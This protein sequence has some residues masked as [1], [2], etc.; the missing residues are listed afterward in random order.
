MNAADANDLRP[1]RIADFITRW[2]A[3]GAAHALNEQQGAQQHFIEL[4]ALL[5]VAPPSGDDDYLFEK[6]ALLLGQRRGYADVFKRGCFAWENKAPGKPLDAALRQLM[7][8]AL[9]LDNPPL[10][11]VSDRLRIEW[12]DGGLFARIEMPPLNRERAA[13]TA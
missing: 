8:Y 4:C 13:R 3:G 11:V 7:G 1:R 5:G 10:L 6:G 9:A 2:S 12:F